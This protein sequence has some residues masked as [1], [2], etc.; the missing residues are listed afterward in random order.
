MSDLRQRWSVGKESKM[1]LPRTAMVAG[2]CAILLASCAHAP[3][4]EAA[5]S[6]A[7]GS[8]VA[9][10]VC[11]ACHAVAPGDPSPRSDTRPF[12]NRGLRHTA[13]LEGRLQQFSSHGHYEM[14]KLDLRPD[15]LRDVAAYIDSL[16]AAE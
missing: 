5:A 9:R 4:D 1:A 2:A 11:A 16:E 13:L 14:P 7:R 8:E 15:E 10:R 6:V 3:D 12:W